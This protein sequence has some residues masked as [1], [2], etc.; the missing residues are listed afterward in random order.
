MFINWQLK[1][2]RIKHQ[3]KLNDSNL[4]LYKSITFYINNSNLRTV[5]KEEI[6]HQILD[7][8]LQGQID[9]KPMNMIIGDDYEKFC[10]DIIEEY[11]MGKSKQYNTLIYFQQYLIWV[12]IISTIMLLINILTNKSTM[13]ITLNEFIVA[14][15]ISLFIIPAVKKNRQKTAHIL[16]IKQRISSINVNYTTSEFHVLLYTF[17]FIL[18]LRIVISKVYGLNALNYILSTT[19]IFRFVLTGLLIIC[20]IEVFKK[21]AK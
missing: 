18:L 2:Q 12:L 15:A 9:N 19:N 16:D 10:K 17:L 7:M 1:R 21:Y 13:G 8:M 14:N 3:K 11:K 4:C 5:E 6:L 20:T